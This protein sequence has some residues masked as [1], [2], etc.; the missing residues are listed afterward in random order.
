MGERPQKTYHQ[1]AAIGLFVA[2]CV[3]TRFVSFQV[4]RC[5]LPEQIPEFHL[6]KGCSLIWLWS[7]NSITNQF[8]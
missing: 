7:L 8:N 5:K 4:K 2:A 6:T 1:L 3:K